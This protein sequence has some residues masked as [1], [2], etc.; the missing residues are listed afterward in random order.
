[1][2]RNASQGS[3]QLGRRREPVLGA[4]PARYQPK[5]P[6]KIELKKDSIGPCETGLSRTRRL[7]APA[8]VGVAS[9]TGVVGEVDVAAVGATVGEAGARVGA[10][11]GLGSGVGVSVGVGVALGAGGTYPSGVR[12]GTIVQVAVGAGV[13]F[14]VGLGVGFGVGLGVG[15]GVE[16]AGG[17]GVVTGVGAGA[18]T[19]HGI[20]KSTS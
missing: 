13:G 3:E 11:V 12:V 8:A 5:R 16:A 7:S 10:A 18:V 4:A 15:F 1:M 6:P 14:T 19:P 17:A 9:G 20:E 2:P